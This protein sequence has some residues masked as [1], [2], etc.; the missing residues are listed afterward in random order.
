MNTGRP[1]PT[2]RKTAPRRKAA[3][4]CWT[5]PDCSRRRSPLDPPAADG[6]V[7]GYEYAA[8]MELTVARGEA[9]VGPVRGAERDGESG[10]GDHCDRDRPGRDGGER[11]E[12]QA[13]GGAKGQG[14]A[15]DMRAHAEREGRE[16]R[17]EQQCCHQ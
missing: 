8:Q 12:D 16:Q 5:R 6:G 2:A 3:A 13:R 1:A 4:Y 15:E 7:W 11:Q 9:A 14:V 17:R 10:I